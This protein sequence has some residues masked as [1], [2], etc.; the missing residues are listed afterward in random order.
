MLPFWTSLLVRTT[1]W[2]VLLQNEG[3]INKI[4]LG[5]GFIDAPLA[6]IRNRAGVVI[7]MTHVLLPF[8]VLPLV[9]VMRAL[10]ADLL[11]AS[12]ACGAR[13]WQSFWRVYW[14]LT[15][16]GVAA[17]SLLV[18]IQSVGYFITPALVGGPDDQMLGTFVAM[19]TNET[20]DWGMAS[21]LAALLLVVV[22]AL[23]ALWTRLAPADGGLA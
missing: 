3:L 4:L 14:P 6:L 20:L 2:V 8:M 19:H 17:G 16:P 9:G 21:A 5:A 18:F 13:P 15:L 11:R 10:R 12:A 22:L 7:A 23:Y 1:A